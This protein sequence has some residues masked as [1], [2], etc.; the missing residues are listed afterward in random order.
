M[1]TTQTNIPALNGAGA[2]ITVR[3]E[4]AS[5]SSLALHTVPEYGGAA[6]LSPVANA[7]LSN[8]AVL[9]ASAGTLFA[10]NMNATES[11]YFMLLDAA[12]VPANGAVAPKRVWWFDATTQQTLDKTFTPP[13]A[14]ATGITVAFSSTGPFTLTAATAAQ[15]A[16]E[17]A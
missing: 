8:G 5:D 2:A 6:A 15:I 14:M 1:S 4:Q 10:L 11:G 17:V 9:K 13:L 12:S 16:G 3:S 7:S